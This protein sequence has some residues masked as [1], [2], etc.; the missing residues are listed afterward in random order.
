MYIPDHEDK[1]IWKVFLEKSDF[2]K[3]LKYCQNDELKKDQ[4]LTK[5]ASNLFDQGQ[6]V[7]SAKV[8][9]LTR[10]GDFEAVALKF[11]LKEESEALLHYLRKRLELVKLSE[12]TQLTMII[13]WLVEIYLNKM[14]AKSSAPRQ[15]VEYTKEEIEVVSDALD[16]QT[17]EELLQLMTLPKV[18][19]CVNQNRNTFYG[20]LGSHG[21]KTNLI[22]FAEVMNDHDRVIRYHLQ[23]KEY[24]PVLTVLGKYIC[25]RQGSNRR[26]LSYWSGALDHLD[27]SA[28][29]VW[30]LKLMMTGC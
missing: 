6:Y 12:K 3:A 15:T 19:E 21:D 26:P 14:G 9:A 7:Q 8:Y 5:Q 24:G 16:D 25:H 22:K 30:S 20:L 2:E 17:S 13:V 11:L 4:V 28:A 10:G 27:K 29:V 1:H 23:D 18:A